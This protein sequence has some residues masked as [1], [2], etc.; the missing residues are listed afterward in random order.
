MNA[1]EFDKTVGTALKQALNS[2]VTPCLIMGIL[3]AMKLDVYA[4]MN[5][6]QKK[7]GNGLTVLTPS[8]AKAVLAQKRGGN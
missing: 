2:G 5:D 1:A 6:A 7:E 3:E 4:H 8:Q